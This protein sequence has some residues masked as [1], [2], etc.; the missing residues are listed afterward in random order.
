MGVLEVGDEQSD[1]GIITALI[2]RWR[3]ETHIIHMRTGEFTI[4]LQDIEVL[5]DIPIDSDPLVQAGVRQISKSRWRELM[6]ELTGWLS[7]EG[8]IK[9]NSLLR[10]KALSKH[11][12][13]LDDID[14]DTD[15]IVVQQRVR[16]YLH[17]L[18]GGTIFPDNTGALLSLD[19]L[20]DIRDLDAMGRKAW[21][22]AALSYLYNS[23]CHASMWNSRE[24]HYYV[25]PFSLTVLFNW[26]NISII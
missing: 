13:I 19:F 4:T 3:P 18:F 26:K 6:F 15:E 5:C 14:D 22:A 16:L 7:E 11:V 8:S 24:F 12:E 1:E 25:V 23:L 20:L 9:G 10:I 2:E 17:W 21:G